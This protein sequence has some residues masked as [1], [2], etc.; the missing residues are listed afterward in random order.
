MPAAADALKQG[1]WTVEEV[2]AMLDTPPAIVARWCSLQILDAKKGRHAPW[3]IPGRSLFLFC[4]RR[5]EPHYRP[6]TAARMLDVEECTVR[7]WITQGR[8]KRLKLG[9]ARKATVLIPE[10]EVLKFLKA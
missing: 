5:L 7:D 10:S 8:L 9:T 3:L 2:A 4:Q 6:A 1:T